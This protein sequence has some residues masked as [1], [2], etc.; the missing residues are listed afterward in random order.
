MV[1]ILLNYLYNIKKNKTQIKKKKTQNVKTIE[2]SSAED[3]Y[4]KRIGA[5]VTPPHRENEKKTTNE[6][7]KKK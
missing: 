6:R 2:N 3:Y 7:R 5:T 4:V 1:A